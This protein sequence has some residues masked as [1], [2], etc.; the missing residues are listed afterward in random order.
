MLRKAMLVA[1]F[2]LVGTGLA[3]ASPGM[4]TASLKLRVGPGT[5]FGVLATMPA[6]SAVDVLGCGQDGWCRVMFANL[7]GYAN[8]SYLNMGGPMPVAGGPV[9]VA[10]APVMVVPGPIIVPRPYLGY[11]YGYGYRRGYGY[12]DGWY[13]HRH[14]WRR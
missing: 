12:R 11:R 6:G 7:T 13:G 8:G 4:T 2:L 9:V 5:G 10:P 1:G 3:A 14:G